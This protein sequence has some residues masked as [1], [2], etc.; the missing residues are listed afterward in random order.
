MGRRRA[1]R[2]RP[3]SGPWRR[4]CS[5][6]RR[7]GASVRAACLPGAEPAQWHCGAGWQPLELTPSQPAVPRQASPRARL[8]VG[9]AT[10]SALVSAEGFCLALL[11]LPFSPHAP[12]PCGLGSQQGVWTL[13][14]G[15]S[16]G[17]TQLLRGQG[18]S[19]EKESTEWALSEKDLYPKLRE[20]RETLDK[21]SQAQRD[22]GP[23]C[24]GDGPAT[25]FWGPR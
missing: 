8:S 12:C 16:Q 5:G 23:T 4:P 2:C 14:P 15:C 25:G 19:P 13:T 22:G 7:P 18:D 11:P 20:P 21:K 1:P 17:H 24:G 9:R 6:L 3:G 10:A